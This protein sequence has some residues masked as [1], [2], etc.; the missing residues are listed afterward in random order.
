MTRLDQLVVDGAIDSLSTSISGALVNIVK[1]SIHHDSC[2]ALLRGG[3]EKGEG[4]M[5]R[6]VAVCVR[7][8]GDMGSTVV[9]HIA[10]LLSCY[11]QHAD[12][13]CVCVYV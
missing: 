8:C 2:R 7:C 11:V 10:Q 5:E 6:L 4:L 1:E 12:D 3:S 13:K 9:R